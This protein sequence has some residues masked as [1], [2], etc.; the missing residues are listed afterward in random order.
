[1]PNDVIAAPRDF[2]ATTALRSACVRGAIAV[3]AF[4]LM[5]MPGASA[6]AAGNLS[7]SDAQLRQEE[8]IGRQMS[9]EQFRRMVQSDPALLGRTDATSVNVLVKLDYDPVARYEGDLPGFAAT[10]PSKTGKKLGENKAAVDAYSAYVATYESK[11][12]ARISD[13][14]PDAK[15][16]HSL[17]VVY[18]GVAMT[19]PA[20][21]TRDLLSIEGVVAV[22]PDSQEKT[23]PAA[24]Q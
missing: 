13:R 11:V 22:Q 2:K 17:R 5:A 8:T 3:S 1:M 15:L 20:N 19:L 24:P 14:I 9:K 12:L 6:M 4:S 16:H 18:G 23:L 7:V 21:R 10:S